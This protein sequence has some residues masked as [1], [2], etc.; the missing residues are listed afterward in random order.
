LRT[1]TLRDVARECGVSVATV[2][3]VVN[4]ASWVSDDTRAKVQ[5]SVD[6]LGYRPNQFA[7]GLKTQ[8]GYAVGVI[9]SDLTN[10]YFT[11]VVRSLSH[12][13]HGTERALLLCDSDHRYEVGNL[14]LRMLF[15]GHIVGL[16]LIGD[17]LSEDVLRSF[18]ARARRTPI[19]AIEREY[20]IDGVSCLLVDSEHGA[21]V[22][23]RHLIE[24]GYQRIAMITGPTEGPGSTTY[25]R[26][27]RFAGYSRAL[28]EAG[29]SVAPAYVAEGNFRYAGG[30][31]A[32]QR[33]LAAPERPDAVFASNDLMALGAMDS[34]REAGLRVP[35]DIALV[36][37]DDIPSTALTSPG[38]TT[39]AMPKG[40]LGS[41]AAELLNQ[42]IPLGGRHEAV[43]RSFEAQLV[44]RPSSLRSMPA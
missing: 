16:V 37:W 34:V 32:M 41:A 19:I 29:R 27:Q 22:V 5:T 26:A 24:Q 12:A 25:G 33:L 18:A 39:V 4:G 10:P 11:E 15:E 2:S 43:R 44:V 9:V 20:D 38:L 40:D 17:N 31:D 6:G 28:R 8:S 13:L 30:R 36:G 42:Q 14:N 7:R 21:H 1:V 35:Q 23:T 3:A